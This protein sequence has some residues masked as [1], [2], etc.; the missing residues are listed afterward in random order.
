MRGKGWE[1]IGVVGVDSGMLTVCDPC[2]IDSEWKKEEFKF[3]E[4]EVVFPNG[5]VEPIVR[6]SKRWFELIEDINSDKIKLRPKGGKP[7]KAKYN[8]SYNA[9]AKIDG[10][11]LNFEVGHA[12]VAVVFNSGLGDGVYPVYAKRVD[13]GGGDIRIAEVRIVML[14]HSVLGKKP[15][16]AMKE[17]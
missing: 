15:F 4:E 11:Q 9:C 6:C 7:K 16:E 12:G 5:K 14:P 3:P 8:F 10:H 1:Q 13:I 17:E 2:Y